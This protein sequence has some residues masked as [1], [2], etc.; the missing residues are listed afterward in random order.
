MN[1]LRRRVLRLERLLHARL[2]AEIQH[3]L[4]GLTGEWL[5]KLSG[6]RDAELS[7]LSDKELERLAALGNYENPDG[8]ALALEQLKR[9]LGIGDDESGAAD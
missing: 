3:L 4:N 7:K 2:D 5:E 8:P 1:G 6:P 9:L